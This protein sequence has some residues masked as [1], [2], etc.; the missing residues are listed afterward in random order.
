MPGLRQRPTNKRR[1]KTGDADPEHA[2]HTQYC[3]N[4][5]Q[6]KHDLVDE[7]AQRFIDPTLN[8]DAADPREIVRQN[9]T[10]RIRIAPIA[11]TRNRSSKGFRNDQSPDCIL[12]TMDFAAC[13][14]DGLGWLNRLGWLLARLRSNISHWRGFACCQLGQTYLDLQHAW[15]L[16]VRI[17]KA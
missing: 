9:N 2:Q 16:H 1:C 14:P 11:G 8:R 3:Q 17:A 6:I 7:S 13:L 4:H 15:N 5:D 12:S 10:I